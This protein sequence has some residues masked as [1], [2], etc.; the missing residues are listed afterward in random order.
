MR[1]NLDCG[2][3]LMVNHAQNTKKSQTKTRNVHNMNFE[4]AGHCG[5]NKEKSFNLRTD[6]AAL[7]HDLKSSCFKFII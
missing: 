2:R 1:N 4:K 7:L 3:Y 5:S 6:H